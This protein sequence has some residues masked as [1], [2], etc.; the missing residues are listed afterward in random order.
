[1]TTADGASRTTAGRLADLAD[2]REQ[3]LH[4]GSASAVERQHGKGKQTARERLT[5]LFDPGSFVELDQLAR[6]RARDFGIDA[7]RPYTDGVIT[8]YGLVEGRQV[9]AFAQDATVFGGSLGATFGAK[10]A[11]V[12]DLAISTGYPV[13]GLNDGG[14]ARIQEG[15]DSL[16]FYMEQGKRHVQASGL[17][18]QISLV[19]GPCAGGAVYGPALTD[20]TVMVDQTAHMFVTGPDVVFAVTGEKASFEELGG[21]ELNA[22][23]SGNAH[24]VAPDEAEAIEWVRTLLSF[25]PSNNAEPA[26]AFDVDV[27][28]GVTELDREL[29]SLVPDS[30]NQGYDMRTAIEHVLDDGHFFQTMPMF[31]RSMLTGFG[32]I[33]GHSVGVVGN[34]PMINAGTL[35]IDASEKAARFVRF[36]DAFGLPVITFCDVPGY[37]PGVQQERL[38]VIRRGAKLIYAY[39]EATVPL[40]TIVTRKAY[41]GGYAVMGSKHIGA[42]LNFAWP[43]AEIA[44]VGGSGAVNILYRKQLEKAKEDGTYDEVRGRLVDEYHRTLTTPY[45]AAE[46][47]YVDAVIAPHETRR[48]V[49]RA[50]RQLRIK[51]ETIPRKKHGNIPL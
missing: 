30:R 13:V 2:R 21:A 23:I 41:G 29:D 11:K 35:D 22:S 26:P 31:G 3:A 10:V 48:Q 27:D 5:Q 49:T 1:M 28:E 50:L 47:G 6:H 45:V 32:R 7:S 33:E 38:G 16:A 19:M 20:F 51:R 8:G 14:G 15:I 18:P 25:L 37:M 43:T 46:R 4:A 12:M 36:C 34:Q 17:V 42:D 44:V 40:V 9:F 24:H 39:C